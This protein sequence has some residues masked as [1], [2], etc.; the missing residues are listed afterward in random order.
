MTTDQRHIELRVDECIAALAAYI[1]IR[2]I[3]HEFEQRFE[4]EHDAQRRAAAAA[5]PV[6]WER[7]ADA[8]AK[9]M[10]LRLAAAIDI[11]K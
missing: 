3:W 10:V 4:G 1:P 2:A 6:L 5:H 11:P 9:Y 8:R 7:F